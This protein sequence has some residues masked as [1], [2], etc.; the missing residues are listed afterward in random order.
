[1]PP[2]VQLEEELA[3]AGEGDFER[4]SKIL[5]EFVSKLEIDF[6]LPEVGKDWT[7]FN[8]SSALND[9][10]FLGRITILDFF[11]YCCVNCLHILPDLKAVEDV[12]GCGGDV[13]VVGVHSAKFENERVSDNISN[14]IQRQV[15]ILLDR[16]KPESEVKTK[17]SYVFPDTGSRI[18]W[19]TTPRPIGGT[20]LEFRAGRRSSFLGPRP[21]LSG[22]IFMFFI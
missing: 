2:I 15:Q 1:M 7:W 16:N 4:R 6:A 11:T 10:H 17:C 14:A 20:N 19:S 22:R 21:N 9:Q 12:H 3:E 18:R 8:V 13:L 5:A